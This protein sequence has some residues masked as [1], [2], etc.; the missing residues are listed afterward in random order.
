MSEYCFGGFNR[1]LPQREV[2]RLDR[3]CR[4]EGG[5]GYQQID[6]SHGT[7]IGGR[8]IG[9]FT[10]PNLGHPFDQDLANRV[11]ARLAAE[12]GDP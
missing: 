12:G 1:R 3:I 11:Y 9:W 10:G 4:E 7:A 2:D 5:Y 8:W 6:D